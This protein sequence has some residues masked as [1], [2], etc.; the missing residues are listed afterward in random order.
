MS[1]FGRRG[2]SDVTSRLVQDTQ[3]SGRLQDVLGQTIQEPIKALFALAL[4]LYRRV[5]S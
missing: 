4:A 2:T 5:G 1:F 3:G